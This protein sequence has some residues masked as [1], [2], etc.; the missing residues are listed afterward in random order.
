MINGRIRTTSGHLHEPIKIQICLAPQN[1]RPNL[2][3]VEDIHV[4]AKK[5]PEKVLK[6][7]NCHLSFANYGKHPLVSEIQMMGYGATA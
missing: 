6:P 5:S 2:S 3:F 4:D 7:E 1:D